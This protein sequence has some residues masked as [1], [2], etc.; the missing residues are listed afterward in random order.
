MVALCFTHNEETFII[1]TN[2]TLVPRRKV[3]YFIHNVFFHV[4]QMHGSIVSSS[5]SLWP[6]WV[7]CFRYV[8]HRCQWDFMF[9][10]SLCVLFTQDFLAPFYLFEFRWSLTFIIE[11]P[12]QNCCCNVSNQLE[13]S[14][15]LPPKTTVFRALFILRKLRVDL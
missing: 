12:K 4:F 14:R 7:Y 10:E 15:K 3:L 13:T 11:L 8:F 6:E 2:I 1:F 9:L 5:V